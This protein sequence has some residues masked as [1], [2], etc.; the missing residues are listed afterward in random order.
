MQ[1]PFLLQALLPALEKT[2][3]LLG[4]LSVPKQL[5]PRFSCS[6]LFAVFPGTS[7]N[8]QAPRN[9]PQVWISGIISA[10]P[11]PRHQ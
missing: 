5:N 8:E 1:L 11:M 4:L 2:T 10:R 6:V 3:Q 7:S 9:Q